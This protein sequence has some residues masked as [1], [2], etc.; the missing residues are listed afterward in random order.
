[1]LNASGTWRDSQQPCDPQT[2]YHSLNAPVLVNPQ[3]CAHQKLSKTPDCATKT[4]GTKSHSG[5]RSASSMRIGFWVDMGKCLALETG[6][7]IAIIG[8]SLKSP[9]VTG[10][11][12]DHAS[13]SH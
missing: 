7:M 10:R 9:A 13:D 4:R 3:A 8:F 6:R 2:K 11:K 12:A 1:M 5:L